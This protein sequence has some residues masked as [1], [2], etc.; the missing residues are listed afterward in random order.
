MATK[1]KRCLFIGLGGTGMTSLLHTKK[2]F[3]ETYGEVPPMIGFL[4]IDTD[5]G[6]YKKD[7]DSKYGPITLSPNEQLPIRVDDARPIYDVNKEHFTW[8]PE[9]NLYALSAM[10]LGAGQVRSNGRFAFTVNHAEVERKVVDMLNAITQANI[11]NNEKYELLASNIEIHMA[12]SLCGGTGCGTFINMAY[13]LK[14]LAPQCKL[15]GYGVLPDVFEAMSS[16]GMAK[17]K[18]NAY[19]AIE[20]LDWLMHLDGTQSFYLDYV[21]GQPQECKERPFNSFIFIDNKNENGDTYSHVDQLSEMIS[22]AFVTSAGELSTASASVS[23]NLEKNIREGT[24]NIENKRAWAAGLGVCEI[25]FRGN[26]ISDIYAIKSAKAIIERLMNS[27][28]DTDTIANSWIDSPEVNIREN[29]GEDNVINFMLKKEPKYPLTAIND[30]QN[31]QAEADAYLKSIQPKEGEVEG[32]I[33]VLTTRVNNAFHLLMVQHIN[34]ECGVSTDENLITTIQA[35]I[36]IF[37]KEMHDEL[38]TLENQRP[39]LENAVKAAV[40]D[41]KD[42][43]KAFFKKS[44]TVN[45]RVE[46][47]INATMRLAINGR[48]IIRRKAAITFFTG[49]QNTLLN[50]YTKIKNIKDILLSINSDYTLRLANIQNRVGCASQTFQIDLAQTTASAVKVNENEILIP[51]FIKSISYP[52]QI[53]SFDTKQKEDVENLIF[54]Y[55]KALPTAKK[56]Q[57]T[58]ID[59]ILDN[60]EEPQFNH[61]MQMALNKAMPLF[62]YNYRGHTPNEKPCDGFYIGVPDK[63]SSRLRKDDH[64]KNMLSGNANLDFA[65]IGVR[66][67][68]I[69]YRQIGVVPAYTI[70]QIPAYEEKYKTCNANCHFDALVLQKMEREDYSLYPKAS[71]DDSIEL[72]VKGFIFGLIK[73][74]GTHYY[75]KD[76]ERGDALDD[77]WVELPS[78]RD[79]AFSEFKKNKVS[80]RKQFNDFFT[81]YQSSKGED[82]MQQLVDDAKLNYFEK[83]SQ[84][85]MTKDQIKAK[86]FETIRKLITSELEY[87]KKEL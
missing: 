22:L 13:L 66:D 34:A 26:D 14:K 45:D 16:S 80:I 43:D 57:E 39:G 84:I 68:I 60:M 4:G 70:S 15:T 1:I 5:G 32:Q 71:V 47:V 81:Q 64:L 28:S 55:A 42:I 74:N 40:V 56:W 79:E 52:E 6:A 10:T 36:N 67:R 37:Q 83:Y 3:V 21:T 9:E 41:L 77:Y 8:L 49:F 30:K 12:F 31:A 85:N 76:T 2:M 86:G 72:W 53:Y 73:N 19:G 27:C 7:L 69:I 58:S 65:S 24:M 25:L 50:A 46:D 59:S 35:Q 23:D 18:P 29:N 62:T 38:E 17:V 33:Q 63:N 78:Y 11:T 87:I 51:Q 48:E 20:D 61:V 54:S 82:A 44:S 75:Y